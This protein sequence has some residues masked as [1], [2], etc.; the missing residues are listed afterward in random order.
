MRERSARVG[1]VI[2]I[3]TRTD[4]LA[5]YQ[6]R[7]EQEQA[8]AAAP[9]VYTMQALAEHP[10]FGRLFRACSALS[11]DFAGVYLV[12]GFVRDLLLD[13]PNVDVDIA[14][15]GDGIEFATRLAA[16][17]GEG[18]ART[19]SSRPP[20]CFCRRRCWGRRPP[21]CARRRA[22]PRRCGH[23]PYRVL[24]LPGGAAAGGA[25]FHPP[26]P[27]PARLHHQRHGHLPERATTS[28]R[29]STS[30]A[31]SATCATA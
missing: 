5:A 9:Q 14:V 2:G 21:G 13:Q 3:V 1:D 11:D 20:S 8:E 24:R 18:C 30:S 17:L 25:R 15:E 31:G 19:A 6:G 26:G 27:L 16:E 23:Y 10:F 7:W 28:A 29:S 12:G 22:L 4:V